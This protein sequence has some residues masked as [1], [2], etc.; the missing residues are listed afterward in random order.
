[1]RWGGGGGLDGVGGLEIEH[2]G[3]QIEMHVF[4]NLC[5]RA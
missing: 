3:S 2:S 5:K 4:E 1:M